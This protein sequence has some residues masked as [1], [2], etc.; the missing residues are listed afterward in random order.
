MAL[1]DVVVCPVQYVAVY[2]HIF[3]SSERLT[4]NFLLKISSISRA[5]AIK[6][7]MA[8]LESCVDATTDHNYRLYPLKAQCSH[9][10]TRCACACEDIRWTVNRM[11][12]GKKL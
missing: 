6:I 7:I 12:R 4:F 8:K 11:D 1:K 2:L 9:F 10:G 5:V 3:F